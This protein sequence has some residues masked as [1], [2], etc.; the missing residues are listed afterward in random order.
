MPHWT[1]AR[2]DS[3]RATMDPEADTLVATLAAEGRLPSLYAFLGDRGPA[4][5]D[6][7]AWI[8]ARD[9]LPESVD[10]AR[11]RR[12]HAVYARYSSLV[13]TGL[14]FKGL[15]EAYAAPKGASHLL[16]AGRFAREP[17]Q[18]LVETARFLLAVMSPDAFETGHALRETLKVRLVHAIARRYIQGHADYDPATGAP[19]NQEDLAG[20]LMAFSVLPLD[21]VSL[22]GADL[23]ADEEADYLYVWQVVGPVLGI[24]GVP[25]DPADGRDLMANIRRR[26]HAPSPAGVVLTDALLD[27]TRDLLPGD[28]FDGMPAAM[29]RHLCGPTVAD[30]LAVGHSRSGQ[31]VVHAISLVGRLTDELGDRS[32]TV[33]RLAEPF[34]RAM[35]SGV[36]DLIAAGHRGSYRPPG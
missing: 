14:L 26:Q 4:P 2:L 11:L 23:S 33:R 34:G 36:V 29:V 1:D 12:G 13:M 22:L 25:D 3:L 32:A 10:R 35:Y 19:V 15:P 16:I 17:R 27:M 20:T 28:A 8:D 7:A 30:H 31:M 18:R 9:A 24:Q 6:V 5:A 21:T